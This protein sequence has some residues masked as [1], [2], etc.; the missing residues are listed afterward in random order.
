MNIRTIENLENCT[1]LQ[2]CM[3]CV[4]AFGAVR[5]P[6]YTT[7]QPVANKITIAVVCA[8]VCVRVQELN[9]SGN[10]IEKIQGLERCARGVC[11][12]LLACCRASAS[13]SDMQ[14]Y[15]KIHV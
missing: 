15:N 12:S 14:Y 5:V 10:D 6:P 3:A 7:W 13:I 11:S 1:N 2:V 4:D 9:L 8:C